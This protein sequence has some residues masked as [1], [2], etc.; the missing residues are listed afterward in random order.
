MII[1][2]SRFLFPVLAA[3][4]SQNHVLLLC[5]SP[6]LPFWEANVQKNTVASASDYK[7]ADSTLL[8]LSSITLEKSC[9]CQKN[10]A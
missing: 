2:G 8:P 6:R 5:L 9:F 1:L 7:E 4:V 10:P 3:W